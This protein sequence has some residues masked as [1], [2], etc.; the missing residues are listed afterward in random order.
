M[1]YATAGPIGLTFDES[2]ALEEKIAEISAK[3]CITVQVVERHTPGPDWPDVKLIGSEESVEKAL[4]EEW[5]TGDPE[6]DDDLV[7]YFLRVHD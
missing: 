6:G 3:Y 1:N 2:K 5:S 4:R 7:K